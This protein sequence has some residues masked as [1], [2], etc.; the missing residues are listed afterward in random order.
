MH[1]DRSG[2][3]KLHALLAALTVALLATSGCGDEENPPEPCG[4][5]TCSGCCSAQGSCVEVNT[6][7]SSTATCGLN[8]SA[9]QTCQSGD[10]CEN[11][12]CVQIPCGPGS[13]T[14]CCQG[15]LCVASPNDQAC[16]TNGGPCDD[17]DLS[18]RADDQDILMTNGVEGSTKSLAIQLAKDFEFSENTTLNFG[19]G[20]AWLDAECGNPVNSSTA[21]SIS[22]C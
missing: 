12:A 21:G 22:F 20:Y 18:F 11:G 5:G 9:C 16:G 19:F 3:S 7:V 17:R 14:G 10:K 4:P 15:G 1:V 2:P 13:C 8:G 6:S